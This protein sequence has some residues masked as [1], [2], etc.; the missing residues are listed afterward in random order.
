MN[1][2]KFKTISKAYRDGLEKAIGEHPQDYALAK[3]ETASQYAD[4]ISG[5]ILGRIK[6]GRANIVNYDSRGWKLACKAVKITASRKSI[7]EYLEIWQPSTV[8]K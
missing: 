2:E 5:L 3:G 8:A 1:Q 7:M 6:D 4:R